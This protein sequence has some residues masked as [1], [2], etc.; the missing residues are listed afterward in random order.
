MFLQ[1]PGCS[2]L[3]SLA[4]AKDQSSTSFYVPG[5]LPP[6]SPRQSPRLRKQLTPSK[7]SVRENNAQ[8][9]NHRQV[10]KNAITKEISSHTTCESIR[11]S[12]VQLQSSASENDECPEITPTQA[13]VQLLLEL[14]GEDDITNM[15][16]DS[17]Q[18]IAASGFWVDE[19]DVEDKVNYYKKIDENGQLISEG[20]FFFGGGG[21]A[22]GGEMHHL[23]NRDPGLQ[24]I[25]S[26]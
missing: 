7:L 5:L 15:S 6:A 10:A 24:I 1:A 14:A 3:W 17:Q 8:N 2:R 16:M 22:G 9:E 26:P 21:G 23:T 25:F 20:C 12:V 4:A 18:M 19:Q 13:N 11:K